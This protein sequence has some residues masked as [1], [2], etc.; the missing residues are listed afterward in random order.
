VA[1]V[2]AG[3]Y[4]QCITGLTEVERVSAK[5][6]GAQAV[7]VTEL[8]QGFDFAHP[9]PPLRDAG[10]WVGRSPWCMGGPPRPVQAARGYGGGGG[11]WQDPGAVMDGAT[12]CW[13][14]VLQTRPH[15]GR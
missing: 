7:A 14:P 11:L 12:G 5:L 15:Y 2:G 8:P 10:L 9:P 6:V 13:G 3:T 4:W 1:E